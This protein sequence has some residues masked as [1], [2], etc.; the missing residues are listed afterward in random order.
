M[1]KH[2]FYIN[3]HGANAA[4]NYIEFNSMIT[5]GLIINVYYITLRGVTLNLAQFNARIIDGLIIYKTLID[6]CVIYITPSGICLLSNDMRTI[7]I[8]KIYKIRK[9]SKRRE[10][11]RVLKLYPANI[12]V[13]S[14]AS[15]LINF[16][17][18]LGL[19]RFHS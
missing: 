4:L 19:R 7:F 17:G 3:R 5:A 8:L 15:I 2:I 18:V 16:R 14:F 13:N 11:K 1:V 12:I 10:F 6:N 9:S